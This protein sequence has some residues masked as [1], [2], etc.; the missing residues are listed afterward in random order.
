MYLI[1]VDVGGTFTDIVAYDL[2]TGRYTFEKVPSVPGE[3]WRGVISALDALRIKGE[4]VRR[5]A[6]GT[7]IATNALLELKGA[8]TALI[9]TRGFRDVL[10]IGK[11]RRM[12]GGL[13]DVFF[14]R[15]PPVV[16]RDLRFEVDERVSAAGLRIREPATSEI[17]ALVPTIRAQSIESIAVCCINAHKNSANERA[18][19]EE[20][21]RHFPSIPI[22]TS[23]EVVREPGE[24]ERTSTCVLNA[25]LMPTMQRYLARLGHALLGRGVETSLAIMGSNGG[26]M[27]LEKA[28]RFV[29]GTFLSGPVG[30]VIA[31]MAFAKLLQLE[32]FIT[33]DMGGT[34]T[35][36]LLVHGGQ[37]RV[38]FDNQIYAYPLRAPQLDIHTIGAGGGSIVSLNADS[39][40]DVGPRSAGAFPGPA[41]YGRGG[42]DPT[43]S[44]ANLMLGRLPA[45]HAIAGNLRLSVTAAQQAFE[46]I[47]GK[48]WSEQHVDATSVASAAISL[49]VSKMG[50][51]VREVSV[52]RGYD[53]R[54]FALIAFGGAGPLHAFLVAM[55]LGM[56]RVVVP[57]FPGHVSAF[58]QMCADYRRDYVASLLEPLVDDH[59]AAIKSPASELLAQA[60]VHLDE[61][62]VSAAERSFTLSLDVRYVGQS[63]TLAVPWSPDVDK[64]QDLALRFNERHLDTFGYANSEA[65]IETTAVRLTVV[66]GIEKPALDFCSSPT[67]TTA[68]HASPAPVLQT[69]SIFDGHDWLDGRVV[70]RATCEIGTVLT[71]P[72]IVEEF[73]ATSYIPAG[74]TATVHPSTALVCDFRGAEI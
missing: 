29:V 20:L 74:W 31:S 19:A 37:P 8:K 4:G 25:Y 18:I 40:I 63:F 43:I 24:F 11:G 65:S 14:R 55:E 51:A 64:A 16:P 56:K 17:D 48:L 3:Q 7:T 42:T 53:P 49:A 69:R 28:S 72:L 21:A 62:G 1:G 10:E 60:T 34:S 39:T 22:I 45:D 41:C 38:S 50:G 66:G 58:G 33:F 54:D 32:N 27:S 12:I 46:P 57:P 70:E 2:S 67:P 5:V 9:T 36:V 26:T 47:V 44:D 35:D 52:H 59:L 61:E 73:G 23:T 71:G 15:P 68:G 6:H 13:F 30:G